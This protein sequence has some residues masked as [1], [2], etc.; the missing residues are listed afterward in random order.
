[1]Q[2]LFFF[3]STKNICFQVWEEGDPKKVAL[4]AEHMEHSVE[5]AKK[6]YSKVEKTGK[7]AAAAG[8]IREA[9]SSK[10]HL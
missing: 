7:S 9:V 8:I 10:C 3:L 6:F 4:L 5:T 2:F 1:M